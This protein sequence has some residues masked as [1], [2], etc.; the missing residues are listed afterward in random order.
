MTAERNDPCP[1]GSGKKYKKCCGAS[2]SPA[3]EVMP[4][5]DAIALNLAI[6]YKGKIGRL[7]E[8]FC[9]QYLEY[10]YR[11]LKKVSEELEA[12]VASKQENIACARGC[13]YCCYLYVRASLQ[14]CET[15]VFQLYHQPEALATFVE[16]Y[17]EWWE[18]VCQIGPAFKTI[19]ALSNRM[20]GSQPG[21][22]EIQYQSA[23][24]D[25]RLQNIRCPFLAHNACSIYD[26]RP[27]VCAGVVASTPRDWCDPT[28]FHYSDVKFYT[29]EAYIDRE[30]RFYLPT[31][32]GLAMGCFPVMVHQLLIKGFGMLELIPGLAGLRSRVMAD[33]EVVEAK[34]L[35]ESGGRREDRRR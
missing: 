5:A 18:K 15:I 7:R 3:G 21:E 34:R 31:K 12:K 33:P 2:A 27:W 16:H 11:A 6:A 9:Q 32:V 35:F 14:E 20:Q 8:Q 26:I 24:R 4:E 28:G 30:R 29:V 25:Y 1:C 19:V 22:I 10:K 13:S 17:Q 23:L